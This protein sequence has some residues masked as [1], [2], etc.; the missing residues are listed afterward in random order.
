MINISILFSALNTM[1]FSQQKL[2]KSFNTSPSTINGWVKSNR[3]PQLSADDILKYIDKCRNDF[4]LYLDNHT[5]MNTLINMLSI[6]AREKQVYSRKLDAHQKNM[7]CTSE[8]YRLFMLELIQNAL[9]KKELQEDFLSYDINT[10]NQSLI[11]IGAEHII[12]VK[13]DGTVYFSGS[14]EFQQCDVYSWRDIIAVTA[15]CK[16]SI[17]LKKNGTCIGVGKNAIGNGEI[18]LWHDIISIA[19]GTFHVLGLK[20]DGTVTAYGTSGSGQCD[21]SS[22]K[23]IIAIAAGAKHSVGLTSD[24]TVVCCG[25]NEHEQCNV[26]EWRNIVSIAAAGDHTIGLTSDGTVFS[27]GDDSYFNFDYWEKITSI[28]TGLYHVVGLKEDGTAIATG[29]QANGQCDVYRWSNLI[30]I[31]AGYF[32]TVGVMANGK[33]VCTKNKY[34]KNNQYTDTSSW[35]LFDSLPKVEVTFSK[36]EVTRTQILSMLKEIKQ[37]TLDYAPYINQYAYSL[38]TVFQNHSLKSDVIIKNLYDISKELWK[39]YNKVFPLCPITDLLLQ[40]HC[41]FVDFYE[42]FTQNVSAEKNFCQNFYTPSS[43]TYEKYITFSVVT[44]QVE[45]SLFNINT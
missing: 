18:F 44:K 1:N 22:W 7:G 15:G 20:S 43:S 23:K 8:F 12:G 40:Y 41:A 21:T 39:L 35:K 30:H 4:F 34:A 19:S 28:S 32:S 9:D 26:S 14:N 3:Q 6:T 27:T 31:Y 2:A 17:G 29:H 42:S 38:D 36:F 37:Y 25:D 5:F 16:N 11:G 24:G 45:S 33:V 10:Q 13:E